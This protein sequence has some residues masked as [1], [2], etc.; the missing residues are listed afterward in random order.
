VDY[1]KEAVKALRDRLPQGGESVRL[2]DA[3]AAMEA[4]CFEDPLRGE[5]PME[6]SEL[7][8]VIVVTKS[9]GQIEIGIFRSWGLLYRLQ[10]LLRYRVGWRSLFL[11]RFGDG[12]GQGSDPK[13]VFDSFRSSGWYRRYA[14]LPAASCSVDW[15]GPDEMVA[16]YKLI[17]PVLAQ[18]AGPEA[19]DWQ[20]E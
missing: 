1:A 16:Q 10:L 11:K 5:G 4:F 19:C 18:A 12:C 9:D 13:P 17:I 20:P 14:P 8:L 7:G 2:R 6:D 3:V 15:Q